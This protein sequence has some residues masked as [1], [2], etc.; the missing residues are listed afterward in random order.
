MNG[1]WVSFKPLSAYRIIY[2]TAFL[3]LY[4]IGSFAQIKVIEGQEFKSY[5]ASYFKPHRGLF[6]NVYFSPVITVDPLGF[7]GKSTYGL[8]LGTRINLW[9]SKTAAKNYSG[10]KLTGMYMAFAYEYYP[11]QYNKMVTSFWIRIKTLIPLAARADL[12]YAS[13]YGLQGVNYR[14][15]FGFELRSLSVFVCGEVSGYFPVS[16]GQHPRELSPYANAGAIMLT[17]PIYTRKEK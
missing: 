6:Y 17:L 5:S 2:V 4:A 13:G 7:G 15:C 11:Q 3:I 1:S 12:I 8:G 14:Y 9:E 16:L 10:L